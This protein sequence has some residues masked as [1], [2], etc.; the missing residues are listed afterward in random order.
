MAC[1]EGLL[2][3]VA[4]LDLF[5][6]ACGIGPGYAFSVCNARFVNGTSLI[7]HFRSSHLFVA[8]KT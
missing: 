2:R 3:A 4:G 6:H 1:G 7:R 5:G 8:L